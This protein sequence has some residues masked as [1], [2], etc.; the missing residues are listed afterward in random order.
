MV[1]MEVGDQYK[2][3]ILRIIKRIKKWKTITPLSSYKD[4]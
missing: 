1:D 3:Y 4:K 2:I